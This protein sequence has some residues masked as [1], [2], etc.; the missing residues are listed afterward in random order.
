M[1]TG[2]SRKLNGTIASDPLAKRINFDTVQDH[3]LAYRSTKTIQKPIFLEN[4]EP[5]KRELPA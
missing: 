3:T 1:R 2:H 4:A 5:S